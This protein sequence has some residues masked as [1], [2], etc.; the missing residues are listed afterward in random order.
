MTST[1]ILN[2]MPGKVGTTFIEVVEENGKST[3]LQGIITALK[4]N[5]LISFKL[6]GVY[7]DTEVVYHVV[8]SE[9]KT[10][11][12][13]EAFIRFK[14]FT[15]FVMI[16][17]GPIFKKKIRTQFMNEIEMLKHLCEQND[18]NE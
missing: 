8:G 10:L 16:F 2:D 6:T 5:Q 4:P 1:Q 9:D 13:V 3:E 14:S 18:E 11:L 12:T 15:K 17:M 7:N